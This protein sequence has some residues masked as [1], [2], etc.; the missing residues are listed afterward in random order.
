MATNSLSNTIVLELLRNK[1]NYENWC[2]WMKNYLLAQDLWD[3]VQSTTEP[4]KPEDDVVGFKA[5][6]KDNAAALHAILI[7]C[8]MDILPE[9]REI[10]SA[11]IVWDKLASMYGPRI[12]DDSSSSIPDN[13]SSNIPGETIFFN[14]HDSCFFFFF[15][16]SSVIS[17]INYGAE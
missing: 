13:S 17:H 10:S 5:W 2:A 9:I 15:F 11:K 16:C 1:D 8:E 12:S 4:P 14:C 7:S 6:T 3:I